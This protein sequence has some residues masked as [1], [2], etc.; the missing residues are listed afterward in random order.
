MSYIN[1]LKQ[2]SSLAEEWIDHHVVSH[3]G[4]EK[5]L[6]ESMRYSLL[7][8]G[9]RLRPVLSLAV[10][11]L[12]EGEKS[13]VLPFACA[14]ELIHTYS[15]IHD[16]L[17]CMDDDDFRRGKP[18][19]H[20]VYGEAMA[21]LAGDALLT[22]SCEILL[23][24]ALSDPLSSIKKIKAASIIMRAAGCEGMIAGQVVDMQSEA[25]TIPYELLCYM[26]ERKTGAILKASVMSSAEL[27]GADDTTQNALSHYADYIGL[28]FQI[29]DDLLDSEGNWKVVGKS[30][31]SD[32]KNK[33]STFVTLLGIDKAK[34]LL[35]V[36]VEDAVK[37]IKNVRNAGFLIK[38][39][40]Y[41][42]ERDK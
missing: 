19:N 11:D 13:I 10:C 7:A 36:T 16:D 33:K 27:C 42:A 1:E 28:A 15:L 22:T 8:G 12:L 5:I 14:I 26:H 23:R 6:T 25:I 18:T 38:T 35:K 32:L 40:A 29:K 24:E 31:G 41:I 30:T 17:P 37:A 9:K 39:A 4:P 2:Y 20:K 3:E 21:L 34:E